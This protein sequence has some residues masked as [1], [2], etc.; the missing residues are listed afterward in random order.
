[1]IYLTDEQRLRNLLSEA[2]GLIAKGVALI[3]SKQGKIMRLEAEINRLELRNKETEI[4]ADGIRLM[5]AR[6]VCEST[7]RKGELKGNSGETAEVV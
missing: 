1:M 3:A 4:R 2:E 5:L 7:E 6:L